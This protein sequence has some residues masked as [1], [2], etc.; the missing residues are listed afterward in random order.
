M[1]PH[2]AL[3]HNANTGGRRSGAPAAR[4]AAMRNGGFEVTP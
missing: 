4:V 1:R 3:W 2:A